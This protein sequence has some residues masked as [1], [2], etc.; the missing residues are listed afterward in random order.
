MIISNLGSSPHDKS[1]VNKVFGA[2]GD[3]LVVEQLLIGE[4]YLGHET[5]WS[6]NRA[7]LKI[8]QFQRKKCFSTQGYS[9]DLPH[10]PV[11]NRI[12]QD[13]LLYF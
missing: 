8:V 7:A 4:E 6:S 9:L 5:W 10:H 3:E 2:A 13:Q 1:K 12:H 11:I